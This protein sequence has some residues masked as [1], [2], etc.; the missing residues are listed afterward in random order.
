[1]SILVS[2]KDIENDKTI[3]ARDRIRMLREDDDD[4]IDEREPM[5][6]VADEL[7]SFTK[8]MREMNDA[9]AKDVTKILKL[10]LTAIEKISVHK[11]EKKDA[12]K[13]D[14]TDSRAKEW[15][16]SVVRRSAGGLIEDVRISAKKD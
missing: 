8:A 1:M 5:D 9:Q 4:D 2:K 15:T 13:V 11:E 10:L 12:L 6:R 7:I 3:S 16:M 14:I